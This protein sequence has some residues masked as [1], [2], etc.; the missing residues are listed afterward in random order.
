MKRDL[1]Q[2]F[3]EC[4]G[5]DNFLE[6]VRIPEGQFV[7]GTSYHEEGYAN[8]RPPQM[9]NVASFYLGKFPVT[10]RQWRAVAKLPQIST[11]IN[12]DISHFKNE[13]APVENVSW[14]DAIEFCKRL[15]KL[16]GKN[17]RLPSEA[18]WEY[19]CRGGTESRYYFGNEL[20]CDYANYDGR[21]QYDSKASVK[22]REQTTPVGTFP[23]N[24]FGLYDMH[25][26]VWEW[27][28][29][30][31]HEDYRGRPAI[32]AVWELGGN[33][34]YR[35]LRGGSWNNDAWECRTTNRRKEP[36]VNWYNYFGFRVALFAD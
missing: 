19:A 23:A 21:H 34:Q 20:S 1:G 10:Q 8:E 9:V 25:G 29:D 13:V 32:A 22:Y 18:E 2:V 7:M 27:C 35:V 15:R 11:E 28:A 30:P 26:N 17:Y 31:W 3:P 24:E 6:L 5:G 33:M 12:P 16:T 4:L 36:A 14:T